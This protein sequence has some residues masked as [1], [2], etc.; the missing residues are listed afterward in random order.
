MQKQGRKKQKTNSKKLKP[1]LIHKIIEDKQYSKSLKGLLR[2]LKDNKKERAKE[3]LESLS[4]KE[5]D[6]I[7]KYIKNNWD[8]EDLL[9]EKKELINEIIFLVVEINRDKLKQNPEGNKK[10]NEML[11][12]AGSN[13]SVS[14]FLK[15]LINGADIYLTSGDGLTFLNNAAWDPH[16]LFFRFLFENKETLNLI[17]P[18]LYSLD[19][20]NRTI[21]QSALSAF[22]PTK[23]ERSK[24]VSY[25]K[26]INYNPLIGHVEDLREYKQKW[27]NAIL[28]ND[29][30]I[31]KG[32]N[33]EFNEMNKEFIHNIN[34]INGI[35]R[36]LIK[37]PEDIN[38]YENEL[39]LFLKIM[40]S[41]EKFYQPVKKKLF[42]EE[43]ESIKNNLNLLLHKISLINEQKLKENPE[44]NR[45]ANEMLLRA[46]KNGDLSLLL[47]SLIQ[48][49]DINVKDKEGSGFLHDASWKSRLNVIRFVLENDGILNLMKPA[50]YDL[51]DDGVSIMGVSIDE[52]NN[53]VDYLKEINYNPLIGH[54]EDLREYKQKWINAILNNDPSIIKGELESLNKLNEQFVVNMINISTIL[55]KLVKDPDEIEHYRNE[56]DFAIR[57]LYSN[58]EIYRPLKE[59]FI[60]EGVQN[61]I[62]LLFN[63]ISEIHKGK[64]IGNI[65]VNRTANEI[66]LGSMEKGSISLFLK[67]MIHGANINSRDEE[68]HTALHKLILSRHTFMLRLFFEED[69][70][71][72]LVKSIFYDLDNDNRTILGFLINSYVHPEIK[73][74]HIV[75]LLN[76]GYNPLIGNV[77]EKF[78]GL[79]EYKQKWVNAILN[80]DPSPVKGACEGLN[81]INEQFINNMSNISGILDEIIKHPKEIE[82]Y[83]NEIDFLINVFYSNESIY[84]V[85]RDKFLEEKIFDKLNL[86]SAKLIQINKKRLRDK[87]AG[88]E[89]ANK[90]LLKAGQMGS[91]S[92]ALKA[93][94]DGANINTRDDDKKT[95][96]HKCAT[97][98]H[99]HMLKFFFE[100]RESFDLVKNI[101]YLLDGYEKS[102]FGEAI[103]AP[104]SFE[105]EKKKELTI[106]LFEEI[107]INPFVGKIEA[108]KSYLKDDLE[109]YK[110]KWLNALENSTTI[111]ELKENLKKEGINPKDELLELSLEHLDMFS[112]LAENCSPLLSDVIKS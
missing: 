62:D 46:G 67:S 35:L 66:L 87:P 73:D 25:L 94:L 105:E 54:V 83:P 96:L 69:A 74:K 70:A 86:L 55:E 79:K 100:N 72:R 6:E 107:G 14:D 32:T 91:I 102:V 61:K 52:K 49:A 110:Q 68:G 16:V 112:L 29:P 81:K 22:V 2:A 92:V 48:G 38:R 17:K 90:M 34:N 21:L 33:E 104:T 51:T 30:S 3:I 5:Q 4:E 45:K 41:D 36:D 93:L 88:D 15:A 23:V 60:R 7:F 78:E 47:K 40:Y 101:L 85:L 89:E 57:V 31:I 42:I 77:E 65:R 37:N 19:E 44:G 103:D 1:K 28:N 106:K 58:E 13:G 99:L 98:L 26:E 20:E 64:I 18:I 63:K 82:K 10:A 76:M 80:N 12:K 11:L 108:R 75:D 111:E 8:K 56:I 59:K 109:Y 39:N 95:F 27:I 9:K 43:L 97:N 71:F 53:V 84:K 50:I 24:F